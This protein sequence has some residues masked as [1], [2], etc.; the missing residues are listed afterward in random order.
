VRFNQGT[1][2][3]FAAGDVPAAFGEMVRQ[4]LMMVNGAYN[5]AANTLNTSVL[6]S[7]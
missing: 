7:N 4:S 5:T 6:E 3:T 2:S 1:H